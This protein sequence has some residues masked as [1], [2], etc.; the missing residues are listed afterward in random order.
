MRRANGAAEPSMDEILAS[1][2][3]II[4]SN[5]SER[6]STRSVEPLHADVAADTSAG[7]A[8]WNEYGEAAYT[9]R[10]SYEGSVAYDLAP[11]DRWYS[12][13]PAAEEGPEAGAIAD[14]WPEGGD[15]E[16][17]FAAEPE[18]PGFPAHAANNDDPR[19]RE[20]RDAI[21]QDRRF[22]EARVA[23]EP[24]ISEDSEAAINASFAE[25]TEAIRAGEL[26]SLE[27]MAQEMLRPM[28][29]QWLEENL[30]RTVQE[31]VREEI[32]R[33]VTRGR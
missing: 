33:A 30:A 23:S 10:P 11:D 25:L 22:D 24:L 18:E 16:P 7:A 20:Y 3:Q 5:D 29:Q 4:E 17:A 32:R 12:E 27:E 14:A 8:N 31:I 1:I 28:M 26:R 2:R 9:L 6:V 21:L 13:E 15:L 19:M